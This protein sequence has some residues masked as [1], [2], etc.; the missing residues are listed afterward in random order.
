ME[1]LSKDYVEGLIN[2]MAQQRNRALDQVA[3]LSG[4]LQVLSLQLAEAQAALEKRR[5]RKAKAPVAT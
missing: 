1:P 5:H 4:Q 3:D 2:A